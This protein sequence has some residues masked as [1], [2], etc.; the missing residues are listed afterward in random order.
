MPASP[1]VSVKRACTTKNTGSTPVR[2]AMPTSR[3][4]RYQARTRRAAM[5]AVGEVPSTVGRNR[6]R[7]IRWPPELVSGEV[8]VRA[9]S[10]TH[11]THSPAMK[12]T[13]STRCATAAHQRPVATSN[14]SAQ[15]HPNGVHEA[16]TAERVASKAL[17]SVTIEL[18]VSSRFMP[19]R[20]QGEG[21]DDQRT[22]HAPGPGRH[23]PREGT[24]DH[25]RQQD[26]GE[27]A[28]HGRHQRGGH[29]RRVPEPRP[30]LGQC[31]PAQHDRRDAGAGG[32]EQPLAPA[33]ASAAAAPRSAPGRGSSRRRWRSG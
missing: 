6:P 7:P 32:G 31:Q 12:A 10:R 27:H 25:A 23:D 26:R 17:M 14:G 29:G 19:E 8:R 18:V 5:V 1:G 2:R 30:D 33:R 16:S 22:E 11:T 28:E 9:S 13:A 20:H 3:L 15:A 21:R 4:S 24:G